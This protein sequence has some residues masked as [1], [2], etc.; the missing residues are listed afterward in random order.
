MNGFRFVLRYDSRE[1]RRFRPMPYGPADPTQRIALAVR[2]LRK[3]DVPDAWAVTGDR[4]AQTLER[5]AAQRFAGTS[6][7]ASTVESFFESLHIRDLALA[8]ACAAGNS[9]AWDFFVDTYR[10]EIYRAARAIGGESRGREIADSL[11]AELYGLRADRAEE[12]KSPFNY[13]LGRSKLGTW[14]HAVLSRKHVDEL[15]RTS[16]LESLDAPANND[17][18]RQSS[19][20]ETA[21]TRSSQLVARENPNAADPDRTRYLALLQ[22][23]LTAVLGALPPRDRL[24]LAYYYVDELTLAQIGKILGEHEATVSRKIERTRR[25][26]REQ[27][28]TRLRDEKKL[29]DAQLGLCYEYAR[30]EWPFDLTAVLA[31]K[32]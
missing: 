1:R 3:A 8:S 16:K 26:I 10:A 23:V 13:F 19:T 31:A 6:P 28:D 2:L 30:E 7:A 22:A 12:R 9:A 29:S 25:D 20:A 4:F 11:Y 24:R 27:V 5:S 18:A 15:R 32:E 14:L 17:G 21:P